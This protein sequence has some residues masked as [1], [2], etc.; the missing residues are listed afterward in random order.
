MKVLDYDGTDH[1]IDKIYDAL[2]SG[3]SADYIV[4]E[5]TSGIWTYRKW[6][7]GIAEAWGETG[8]KTV[9]ITSQ[10]GGIYLTN[11]ITETYQSDIFQT[12]KTVNV[13]KSSYNSNSGV[14]GTAWNT[15]NHTIRYSIFRGNSG[16][17]NQVSVSIYIK[18]LWKDFTP[19]V[20][21]QWATMQT[22][23]GT[24]TSAVSSVERCYWQ[25]FGNLVFVAFT[26]TVASSGI[27][28]TSQFFTGLPKPVAYFRF[29]GALGNTSKA[30][31]MSMDTNGNISNA[32]TVVGDIQGN[33]V[34]GCVA[35]FTNE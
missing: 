23:N 33:V 12:I 11:E 7:S 30:C 27:T 3:G 16:G 32:Y 18:G 10:Q 13:N 31:R 28:T 9:D 2:N 6:A 1:L 8:M 20:S 17:S 15:E 24:K 25:K 35:Y 29:S 5:G 21:H 14:F 34:D 22:G 26:F 19:S 4:E